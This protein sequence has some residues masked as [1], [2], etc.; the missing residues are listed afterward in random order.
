MAGWQDVYRQMRGGIPVSLR[1]LGEL[2]LW[3]DSFLQVSG[4]K[5]SRREGMAVDRSGSPLP[6]F[7][8]PAIR[9]LE[10]RVPSDARVFEFGMGNST[11]WWSSRSRHVTTC[12]GDRG[13]YD[14][15]AAKMP[16]NVEAIVVRDTSDEYV[17]AAAT[18]GE[19]FDIVS[20]DGRRRVECCRNSLESLTDRGVVIWDDFHRE[21]YHEGRKILGDAGFR[22]LPF[23]GMT[24]I[25]AREAC[26]SVF[27]RSDNC[28]GI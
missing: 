15:I 21:R 10:T 14:R 1:N 16:G 3:N 18:R 13:W 5:R 11:L 6:W 19:K 2:H 25:T 17:R 20:I 8:Y 7:T 24:P 12:E 4:W 26:T 27:Y 23:S 9:F 28:L 22:E